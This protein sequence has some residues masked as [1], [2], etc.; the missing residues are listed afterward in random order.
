M[1]TDH[2]L[3]GQ[4]LAPDEVLLVGEAVDPATVE[5]SHDL[6][7]ELGVIRVVCA[8]RL[9]G[10]SDREEQQKTKG[11]DLHLESLPENGKDVN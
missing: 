6:D 9:G 10:T 2:S 11:W 4:S 3:G 1:A 8:E 7:L 5:I